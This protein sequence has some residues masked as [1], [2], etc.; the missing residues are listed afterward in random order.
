MYYNK[1]HDRLFSEALESTVIHMM[2][3]FWT[4]IK[5]SRTIEQKLYAI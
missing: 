2:S 3:H 4:K 1:Y 5:Y